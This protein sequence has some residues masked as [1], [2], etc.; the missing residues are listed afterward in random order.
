MLHPPPRKVLLLPQLLGVQSAESLQLSAP[1]AESLPHLQGATLPKVI[2]LSWGGSSPVIN[3]GEDK[4][5]ATLA[6][7]RTILKSHFNSWVQG[8]LW[9]LSRLLLSLHPSLTSTPTHSCFLPSCLSQVPR[10]YPWS[11]SFSYHP[12][13]I[14]QQISWLSFQNVSSICFILSPQLPPWSSPLSQ[15]RWL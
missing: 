15:A 8:S 5:L 2:P 13:V 10:T 3:W 11:F 12:T 9:S 6:Q 14:Y 1:W 7:L 4:G